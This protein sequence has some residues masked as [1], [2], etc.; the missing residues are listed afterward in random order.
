MK[1]TRIAITA[2]AAAALSATAEAQ[3]SGDDLVVVTGGVGVE[4]RTALDA[5]RDRYN[6]RLAFA[7][8]S[9]EYVAAV[10]V[11]LTTADGREVYAGETEGPF[12]LARL[13]PG[14]Y[15]LEAEYQGM[16]QA[17]TFTVGAAQR[18]PLIYLRWPSSS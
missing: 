4:E 5:E 9:G 18:E 12:M 16:R 6:L 2:F 17:R 13:P 3:R 14:R 11:R 15:R 10:Q 7:E 8:K 1:L